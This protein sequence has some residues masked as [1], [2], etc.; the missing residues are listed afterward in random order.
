M[1]RLDPEFGI[2]MMET[3]VRKLTL[4]FINNTEINTHKN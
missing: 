1:S 4:Q 3:K 2:K